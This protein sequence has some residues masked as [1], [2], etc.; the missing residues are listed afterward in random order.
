MRESDLIKMLTVWVTLSNGYALASPDSPAMPELLVL[1]VPSGRES[2]PEWWISLNATQLNMQIS[3]A[4]LQ[5]RMSKEQEKSLIGLQI[6]STDRR[7]FQKDV[8]RNESSMESRFETVRSH[9]TQN[10]KAVFD[11]NIYKGKNYKN[12]LSD[13]QFRTKLTSYYLQLCEKKWQLSIMPR[14]GR[15]HMAEKSQHLFSTKTANGAENNITMVEQIFAAQEKNL[16]NEINSI[17]ENISF[18]TGAS[19]ND[20]SGYYCM[21]GIKL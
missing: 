15:P 7:L 8:K 10:I 14:P 12:F 16:K 13:N 21:D 18:L 3:L 5:V 19:P 17:T 2:V 11:D 6:Q 4:T 20:I 9:Q 1:Q